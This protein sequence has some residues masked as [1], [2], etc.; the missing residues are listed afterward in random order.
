MRP[1]HHAP[2][3]MPSLGIQPAFRDY[4]GADA[5]QNGSLKPINIT[6]AA[7]LS[8]RDAI[9]RFGI[10]ELV[11]HVVDKNNTKLNQT[12][13][14]Q[15]GNP[16]A[17]VWSLSAINHWLRQPAQRRELG[18]LNNCDFLE[19]FFPLAGCCL[20]NVET[21]PTER[22]AVVFTV[23][24]AG[25]VRMFD[26]AAPVSGAGHTGEQSLW[27]LCT[28]HEFKPEVSLDLSRSSDS[29]T[30]MSD[31]DP[32][33]P[34][35]A[36]EYYWQIWGLRLPHGSAPGVYLYRTDEWTGSA[37]RIGRVTS[38]V[39]SKVK[40]PSLRPGQ[41]ASNAFHPKGELAD[42]KE[43]LVQQDMLTIWLGLK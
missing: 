38:T 40:F 6:F 25:E 13:I 17:K 23:C 12:P 32:S 33:A 9:T 27:Q 39:P 16:I 29:K 26:I 22:S 3:S 41:A 37:K 42:Y 21:R 31:D 24:V 43:A 28:K 11:Y 34:Q 30:L 10:N 20:T 8:D 4:N 18:K 2:L 15:I 36:A 19:E 1:Q 14:A 7:D 35:P 5:N